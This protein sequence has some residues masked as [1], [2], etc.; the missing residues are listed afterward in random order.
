MTTVK[1]KGNGKNNSEYNPTIKTKLN[2]S[3]QRQNDTAMTMTQMNRYDKMTH[4]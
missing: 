3:D 2:I 4:P 1:N